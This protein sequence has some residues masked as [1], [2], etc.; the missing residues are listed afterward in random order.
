[1]DEEE[2]KKDSRL[3][4]SLS[5]HRVVRDYQKRFFDKHGVKANITE[6]TDIIAKKIESVGG[7]KV[8]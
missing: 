3:R 1:M 7:L 4:C 2:N 8:T 6:I 5:F